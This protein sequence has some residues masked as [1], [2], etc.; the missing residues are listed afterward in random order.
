LGKG[1][2]D[3]FLRE[4]MVIRENPLVN[5]VGLE[6]TH[7]LKKMF[8]LANGADGGNELVD[9]PLRW[10]RVARERIPESDQVA[11]GIENGLLTG[12]RL[13][14][15]FEVHLIEGVIGSSNDDGA[16]ARDL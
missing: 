14:L 1:R 5:D 9:E 7:I 13:Y 2:L 4:L 15:G 16:G 10:C 11:V 8:R 12:Q 3:L 6:V